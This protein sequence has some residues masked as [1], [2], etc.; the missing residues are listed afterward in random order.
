MALAPLQGFCVGITADRRRDELA[1]L[2]HRRGATTLIAPT[3]ATRFLPD[4][5]GL[6]ALTRDLLARPPDIVVASTGVGVR[7]WFEAAQAWG[8]VDDLRSACAGAYVVARGPKAVAAAQ[9]AGLEVGAAAETERLEEVAALVR[10]R[11]MGGARV[12]VQ[13]HGEDD[14]PLVAELRDAG[15]EVVALPVYRWGLPSDL[16]PAR[17]LVTAAAGRGV[18]AVAFTSAP[19]VRNFFALADEAGVGGEVRSAFAGDVVA[20]CVGPVCAD[21]A[22]SAGVPAPVAPETGRLGLLVRALTGALQQRTVARS[23]GTREIVLQGAALWVGDGSV[24]DASVSLAP[25]EHS[26]LAVLVERPGVVV[27]KAQLLRQVWSP[28]A[29]DVHAV[30]VAV[31]RL[32][33]RVAPTGLR[34]VAVRGRGYALE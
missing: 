25:R 17:R 24:G 18:D 33:R 29:A 31:A 14:M 10:A 21:A 13:L 8:V 1:A 20:A 2:L 9:A 12:A 30:D 5:A 19:A 7:A 4:D 11:E 15:A 22:R 6:E 16:E 28:G 3:L 32:R 23:V 27:P 34:I 26:V